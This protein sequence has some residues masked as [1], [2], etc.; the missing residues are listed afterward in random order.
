MPKLVHFRLCPKSR[1]VRLALAELKIEAKLEDERPW[2]WRQEFLALNPAGE[3]PVYVPDDGAPVCGAY[4]ISEYLA[5]SQAPAPAMPLFPGTPANRAEI[6]RL[7]DWFHGKL[8]RESSQPLIEEKVYSRF[9]A[10]GDRKPD[11][12]VL[13][14][15]RGNLRY[16][17][18]YLEFLT[19]DRNWLAGTEPSFADFCA[20]AHLSCLDYLDEIA[21]DERPALRH[22]YARMKSRPSLRALLAERVPGAPLPPAHYADPDF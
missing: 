22:W 16:H 4:A 18:G 19:H 3:L 12:G 13:R 17:L 2:E 15:A 7:V 10:K 8:D 11:A 21:W 14:G 20:A 6:R 5:D 9:D 1:S